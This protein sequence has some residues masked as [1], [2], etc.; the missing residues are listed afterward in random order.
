MA[1]AFPRSFV[2]TSNKINTTLFI[3]RFRLF[4]FLK[5]IFL[6]RRFSQEE[7]RATYIPATW[8]AKPVFVK[9]VMALDE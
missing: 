3:C 5:E 2:F 7:A 9:T 8:P 1:R 6:S 4:C